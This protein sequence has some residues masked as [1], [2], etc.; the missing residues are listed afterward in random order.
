MTFRPPPSKDEIDLAENI[1]FEEIAE[2]W[3]RYELTDGT[4]L[5]IKCVLK[6]VKKLARKNPDG[7]N[8]YITMTDTVLRSIEKSDVLEKAR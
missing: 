3:N 7:S 5:G 2:V 1:D 4:V 8:I 6:G